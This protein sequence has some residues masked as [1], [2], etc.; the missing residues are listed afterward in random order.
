[1]P[2]EQEQ[3][4]NDIQSEGSDQDPFAYLNE[5]LPVVEPDKPADESAEQ[6]GDL[7]PRN[8]RERRLEAR[9]QAE[10]DAGI[11]LA[12]RLQA[13]EEQRNSSTPKSEA[14]S[15][16]ERLYGVDSPEAREA[17][18]LLKSEFARVRE[19]ATQ[20]ALNA[21][22]ERSSRETQAVKEAE[23]QLDGMLE[24]IEDEFD[25]DMTPKA[26]TDFFKLLER[27]SPKDRDGNIIQYADH[28]AVWEDYQLRTQKPVD[29]TAKNL[30][31][32]AMNNGAA[33]SDN[34]LTNTVAERYLRENGI[35]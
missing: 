7:E 11:Q 13:L 35:I 22:E 23:R 15:N 3:F 5:Q 30:A 34:N 4:L 12:A 1:M 29:N 9:L 18:D 26:R 17:T 19:E 14:V 8:R 2:S 27:M 25:V 32:R 6:N 24:E 33:A 28:M 31:A 20:A 10:R 16:I 21:L